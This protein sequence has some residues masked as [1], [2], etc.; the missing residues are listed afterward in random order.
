VATEEIRVCNKCHIEK[1]ISG[2]RYRKDE[3]IYRGICRQ[4]EW[5]ARK[6]SELKNLSPERKKTL[7]QYHQKKAKQYYYENIE[8]HKEKNRLWHKRNSEY[9]ANHSRQY[10]KDNKSKNRKYARKYYKTIRKNDFNYIF[11]QGIRDRI[12]KALKAQRANKN[13]TTCELTGCDR[14]ELRKYLES[15]FTEGMS[16][17]NQGRNGW[18]I[19]HIRPCVSFDLTDPEQQKICFHY[20]NLQ[21]LWAEDNRKKGAKVG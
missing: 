5:I 11:A 14:T 15:L 3:R 21:P 2:Y 12:R 20:S 1:P 10:R 7:Q 16:W 19:D 4:C 17:D 9:A 18:H 6:K 8:K 13:N